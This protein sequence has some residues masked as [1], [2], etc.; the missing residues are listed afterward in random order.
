MPIATPISTAVVPAKRPTTSEFLVLEYRRAIGQFESHLPASGLCV[1]RVNE[2]AGM[3]G[4]LGGPPFFLYYFRADGTPSTDGA[5]ANFTCLSAESGRTQLNDSSNPYCF[6]S[7]GGL[8]G[9]NI[10]SVGSAA[11]SS[12][13]FS[14]G[15][16]AAV[17]K[18]FVAVSTNAKAVQEFGFVVHDQDFH[19]PSPSCSGTRNVTAW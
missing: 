1:T 18:H 5:G 3:W 12:I 6:K 13:S 2:S 4:N 14:L 9:I 8:C 19:R 11:G 10:H 7:D 17:A 16:P 15:D